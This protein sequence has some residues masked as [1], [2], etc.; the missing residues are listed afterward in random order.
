MART[1]CRCCWHRVPSMGPASWVLLASATRS[2]RRCWRLP[3]S[4]GL[5]QLVA[6]VARGLGVPSVNGGVASLLLEAVV[7]FGC[8]CCRWQMSSVLAGGACGPLVSGDGCSARC[9]VVGGAGGGEPDPGGVSVWCWV[10]LTAPGLGFRDLPWVEMLRR[11][12]RR[13]CC[14]FLPAGCCRRWVGVFLVSSVV[15]LNLPVLVAGGLA[16]SWPGRRRAL[17]FC[18]RC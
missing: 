12:C 15:F 9:P 4:G 17:C 13:W 11:R 1:W 6:V 14:P 5:A 18:R 16:G 2:W 3:A 8:S 10:A 7:V